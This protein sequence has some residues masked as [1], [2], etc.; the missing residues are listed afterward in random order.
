[1]KK[2][3]T[4]LGFISCIYFFNSCYQATAQTSESMAANGEYFLSKGTQ[5][6]VISEV[7][8][9]LKIGWKPAGGIT[10]FQE[11]GTTYY[12]QALYK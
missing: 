7:N 3:F 8:R 2:A 5:T 4:L 11:R 1:M 9:R 10:V 6:Q 12:M